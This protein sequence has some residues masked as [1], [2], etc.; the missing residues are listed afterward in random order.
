MFEIYH[1]Y[2]GELN[3]YTTK[4]EMFSD[5]RKGI[6]VLRCLHVHKNHSMEMAMKKK[7]RYIS[8]DTLQNECIKLISI[9]HVS[10]ILVPRDAFI[11]PANALHFIS[12]K[13]MM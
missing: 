3:S 10:A 7:G 9:H 11:I 2:F 6:F 5:K 1:Y 8:N 12:K 4:S 13:R